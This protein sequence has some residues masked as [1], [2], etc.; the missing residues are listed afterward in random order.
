MNLRLILAGAIAAL[1]LTTAAH[2]DRPFT[3]KDLATYDVNTYDLPAR[4]LYSLPALTLHE[5][6]PGHAF[7]MPIQAEVLKAR[8][9]PKFRG[10]YIV[11]I[12]ESKLW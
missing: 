6:A 7:Q 3:A 11:I 1:S 5:S 10:A 2:A 8:H 12:N 9:L 4:P